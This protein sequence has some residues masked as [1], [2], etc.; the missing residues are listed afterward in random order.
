MLGFVDFYI[1]TMRRLRYCGV[2]TPLYII[3]QRVFIFFLSVPQMQQQELAQMRQRDANLTALAAIGPRKKRKVDSP[4]A[5]PSGTEVRNWTQPEARHQPVLTRHIASI[6]SYRNLSR[7]DHH[8]LSLVIFWKIKWNLEVAGYAKN[9]NES[10][11][12]YQKRW[13]IRHNP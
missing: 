6:L 7:F 8:H 11:N 10:Q 2:G 13:W 9:N 3:A 4:G 5:T 12:M 1:F